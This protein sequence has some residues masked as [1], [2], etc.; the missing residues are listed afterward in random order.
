[1]FFNKIDEF[2]NNVLD[3]YHIELKTNKIIGPIKKEI[4]F[5]KFQ[6]DID[7]FANNY[8]NNISYDEIK[9][10]VTSN[11]GIKS[12]HDVIIKY[13]MIYTFLFIGFKYG[14]KDNIFINNIIEYS[15][16]QP[17]YKIKVDNFFNSDSNSQI[18]KM[19]HIIKNINKVLESEKLNFDIVKSKVYGEE[20]FVF[21]DTL[22]K[23][24]VKNA[25]VKSKESRHNLI[26]TVLILLKYKTEDKL[27]LYNIIEQTENNE[28]E[29][30]FIDIIEP[31]DDTINFNTIES[32]LPPEEL[33]KGTAHEIWDYI[34][35]TNSLSNQK[36]DEEK[37]NI[38]INAGLI[39]PI[40]DDFLLYHRNEEK[41]DR[42]LSEKDFQKKK[43]DAK[44][45]YII[46]KI[47]STADLYSDTVK[48]DPILHKKIMENFISHMRN[49][50]AVSKNEYEEI[51]ILNKFYNQNEISSDNY[52]YLTE[53]INFRKYS[54]VNFND[55]K[56]YGFSNIFTKTVHAVR[57]V[58]FDTNEFAQTNMN[59]K[60]QLRVGIKNSMANIIGFM[61]PTNKKSIRCISLNET[62]NVRDFQK[63]NKKNKNGF[64]IFNN[65]LRKSVLESRKHSSS[66]YWLFDLEKDKVKDLTFPKNIN[67]QGKIKSMMGKIYDMFI[68]EVYHYCLQS[69]DLYPNLPINDYNSIITK[70]E[71]KSIDSQLTDE[72]KHK[73]EK[74]IFT[75]MIPKINI[76][77]S[78]YEEDDTLYG[79]E[80]NPVKLPSI[81]IP[82]NNETPSANIDLSQVDEKGDNI[83][84]KSIDGICQHNI[85]WENIMSQKRIDHDEYLKQLYN[86]MQQYVDVNSSGDYIC[87]SC[88]FYLDIKRYTTDGTFDD[89]TKKFIS[90]S[91]P[92]DVNLEDIP[93]YQRYSNAIKNMDKNVEKIASSVGIPYYVGNSMTI[94]W[95]RKDI[96][97]NTIDMLILNNQM[98]KP[99][100]IKRNETKNKLYGISSTLSN[101][102][103]F[104][105]DPAIFKFSSTDKDREQFKMIKRNNITSY[106]M[107]FMIMELN[108][109]QISFFQTDTKYF[110]DIRYFD[111]VYRT[112]FGNLKLII[113]ND[114]HTANLIDYKI[115][116]YMIFML[117]AKVSKHRLWFSAQTKD[118][119]NIQKMIPVIQRYIIHT[120]VDLINAILE[121]SFNEKSDYIFE[122]FK[123]KFYTKLN[124]IFKDTRLYDN[125]MSQFKFKN[126]SIRNR[127][128]I[129]PIDDI[130]PFKYSTPNWKNDMAAKYKPPTKSINEVKYPH[131]TNM[132]HCDD[133]KEHIFRLKGKSSQCMNC[134]KIFSDIKYDEKASE[135]IR[136]NYHYIRLN[137]LA[138][139]ICLDTEASHEYIFDSKSLKNVCGRCKNHEG[140]QYSRDD[141]DKLNVII[142][143]KRNKEIE[144]IQL[145]IDNDKNREIKINNYNQKV[146]D[147]NKKQYESN[148][149]NYVEQFITYIKTI[150]GNQIKGNN[151]IDIDN[152]SY[153]V[154]HDRHGNNIKNKIKILE[155]DK[156]IN[157]KK[158]HHHFGTDV[159]YYTDNTGRKTNVFYNVITKK[160][161]GYKEESK[162]IVDV[163]SS[164][165]MKINYSIKN[166]LELFGFAS[167]YINIKDNY[168]DLINKYKNKQELF[169]YIY[170]DI[171]RN[172]LDNL[173][174]TIIEFQRIFTRIYYNY[175]SSDELFDI[176]IFRKNNPYYTKNRYGMLSKDPD[177]YFS[178]DTNKLIQKYRKRLSGVKITDSNNKHKIFKHWKAIYRGINNINIKQKIVVDSETINMY[179]IKELEKTGE[180]IIYYIIEQWTKLIKYNDKSDY[181]QNNLVMFLM[182]FI[183]ITFYR[184]NHELIKNNNDI[185]KF[186]FSVKSPVY[187]RYGYVTSKKQLPITD[188][189]NN[190]DVDDFDGLSD[191]EIQNIKDNDFDQEQL[192]EGRDMDNVDMEEEAAS[193]FDRLTEYNF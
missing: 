123:V 152:N 154:N 72:Y 50:K 65:F 172:R 156:K 177:N 176:D 167:E 40:V 51:K 147:N 16:N 101:L 73:L 66:L 37:I 19:F 119:K 32:I 126:I 175:E 143:D 70:I 59:D 189:N 21:L 112:I 78:K 30:M 161:I 58:N 129:I 53:L 67:Q 38:L 103:V 107:L 117:S 5:T 134:N 120:I 100:F 98:L 88:G 24:F 132:T 109:S 150:V 182:E 166:K 25:F 45:R 97:K 142:N 188:T 160:L 57:A 113:N 168:H 69:I 90:F 165:T 75:K 146:I 3:D 55:F 2:I 159:I 155:T 162:N 135:K 71:K 11:D 130:P 94:S 89:T 140:K 104:E 23:D 62:I 105:M 8:L 33:L 184:Y 106:M 7:T 131:I 193:T 180:E 46:G 163:E 133:G 28:G 137:E 20:T 186:I 31:I 36:S 81:I 96:I 18:I 144:R 68:N 52:D 4:N 82:K 153:I 191:N 157:I 128:N 178:S 48:K 29:Y 15:R 125:I 173:K 22:D 54:Y 121:N 122:I 42:M 27:N 80:N 192:D 63:K 91:V 174:R 185:Q 13:V 93:K 148:S 92:M 151:D 43:D 158:N 108:E 145:E 14:G 118:K 169:K 77:E 141:L 114:G 47:D 86:F 164:K 84:S 12:I 87:K 34:Q 60:L 187:I 102:F 181:I 95:R 61:I 171:A 116:C 85:T 136:K 138:Q 83:I 17:Q 74:Y 39:V 149:K 124:T 49:R 35:E 76:Q 170:N 179:D 79:L 99:K 111:R 1:M 10:N 115:L 127:S 183:N 56:N 26:K 44:I 9:K 190:D 110:A 139:R 41:Y 6:K 64:Y